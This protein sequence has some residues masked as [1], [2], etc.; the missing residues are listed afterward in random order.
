MFTAGHIT[1][2]TE[3]W[4]SMNIY[5]KISSIPVQAYI[6]PELRTTTQGFSTDAI[7]R[8]SKKIRISKNLLTVGSNSDICDQTLIC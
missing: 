8:T 5:M 3:L 2:N 7:I 1:R 4:F 6:Q